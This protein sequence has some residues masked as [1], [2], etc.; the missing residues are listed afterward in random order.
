[1]LTILI[2]A[3]NYPWVLIQL[4]FSYACLQLK[5]RDSVFPPKGETHTC[6]QSITAQHVLMIFFAVFMEFSCDDEALKKLRELLSLSKRP[7]FDIVVERRL[8]N[9]RFN[10][11]HAIKE[12]NCLHPQC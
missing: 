4:L 6:K 7:F 3:E 2:L 10:S 12:E 9:A 1:M 5:K 8:S 11:W